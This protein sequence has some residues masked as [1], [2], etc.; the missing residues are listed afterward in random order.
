MVEG[1]RETEETKEEETRPKLR[2]KREKIE[3]EGKTKTE[4]RDLR[5]NG[6]NYTTQASTVHRR[7]Q[8]ENA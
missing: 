3:V 1:H 4:M 7:L 6:K 8:I 5:Q 2:R